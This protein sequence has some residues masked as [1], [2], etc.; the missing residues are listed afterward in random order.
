M[1]Q[2]INNVLTYIVVDFLSIAFSVLIS[3]KLTTDIGSELEIRILKIMLQVFIAYSF[4]DAA[5]IFGEY[6]YI[7]YFLR[8][9]NGTVCFLSVFLVGVLGF[10]TLVYTE[11]RLKT[12]FVKKRE[13]WIIASLPLALSLFM[14]V[15]SYHTGWIF[16]ISSDNRYVRGPYYCW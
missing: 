5:W 4:I 1:S 8:S 3:K 2:T 15:C 6:G 16:Y 10:L 14:C 9:V 11:I 13:L 12:L 7:P